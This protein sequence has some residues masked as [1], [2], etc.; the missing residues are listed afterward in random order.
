M[1]YQKYMTNILDFGIF[2]VV[3]KMPSTGE[4]GQGCRG[5]SYLLF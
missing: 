5:T 1:E 3:I 4:E 2:P